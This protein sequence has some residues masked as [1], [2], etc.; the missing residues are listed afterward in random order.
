[1]LGAL[2]LEGKG[3]VGG[4]KDPWVYGFMEGCIGIFPG[5]EIFVVF[6]VFC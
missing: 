3:P 6:P 5:L 2:R 4:I 1:M